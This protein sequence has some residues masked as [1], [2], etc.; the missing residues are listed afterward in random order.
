MGNN[1][2]CFFTSN[3]EHLKPHEYITY[4]GKLGLFSLVCRIR[5]GVKN[6]ILTAFF[7][8][9]SE[10]TSILFHLLS[11]FLSRQVYILI[12]VSMRT[13]YIYKIHNYIFFSCSE[14]FEQFLLKQIPFF[15]CKREKRLFLTKLHVSEESVK[16][17]G[18]LCI[19]KNVWKYFLKACNGTTV[20]M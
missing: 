2:P 12:L 5:S 9:Q 14:L 15:L 16:S 8:W 3:E 4:P 19:N 11:S 7:S 10:C 6:L 18:C 17:I 13:K 1:L 20:F